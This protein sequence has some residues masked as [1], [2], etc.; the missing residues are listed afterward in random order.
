[1]KGSQDDPAFFTGAVW[2]M[3]SGS[4]QVRFAVDGAAGVR[5]A[6]VPVPAVPLATL[7]MKTGMVVGLGALAL[8]LLVSMA[9]LVGAAVREARL[10][11]GAGPERDMA[12]AGGGSYCRYSG[13]CWRSS[14][15]WG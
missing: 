11:P 5:T 6:A 10:P 1:M 14:W 4:W 15:C 2:M 7:K 9:G 3:A 13:G 12:A 8:F